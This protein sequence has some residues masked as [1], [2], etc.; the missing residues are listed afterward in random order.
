[1]T[2]N[3]T[4]NPQNFTRFHQFQE[5]MK[6]NKTLYWNP[7]TQMAMHKL[8]EEHGEEFFRSAPSQ[9]RNDQGQFTTP[10][11]KRQAFIKALEALDAL[12]KD[13]TDKA[14]QTE[15]TETNAQ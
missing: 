10:E 8:A 14:T 2:N 5:L 9:P 3:S 11:T 7:A 6:T 13:D 4:P 1:M 12:E 15:G